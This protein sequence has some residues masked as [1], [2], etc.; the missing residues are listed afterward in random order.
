MRYGIISPV[1]SPF[2]GN[3]LDRDAII[4]LTKFLKRIGVR[5]LFPTGST[6]CAP[7]MDV[8]QHISVIRAYSESIKRGMDLLPGVGRNSISETMTVARA[9]IK[10]GAKALVI[11]TPYYLKMHS[12][13]LIRY[14]DRL[15][16]LIDADVIAYN[17]PQFTGNV[18][19][20]D[21][22][23][24]IM[25]KHKNLIGIKDSS[26]NM[27]GF[28][29]FC[30][31]PDDV[32]VFQGQDD[33]LLKSLRMGASGGICGTT[34]FDGT[35]VSLFTAYKSKNTAKAASLQ[36]KV[37]K[38]M[39]ALA[40]EEFPL[41]YHYMFYKNVMRKEAINALQPFY[42]RDSAYVASMGMRLRSTIG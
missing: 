32:M 35:A 14:Y 4:E 5:G 38:T 6:G 36:S 22:F 31:L 9:A 19:S 2:N 8:R 33:L 11:V 39:R 15:L 3:S 23:E 18:L 13:E 20:F 30:S 25:R 34:N 16:N 41:G 1:I 42:P 12:E 24:R 21:A 17:I 27:R 29:K 26:K 40:K 37:D 28:E 10:C 7:L